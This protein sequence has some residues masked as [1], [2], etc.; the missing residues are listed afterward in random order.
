MRGYGT[1]KTKDGEYEGD[2][3]NNMQ[4]GEG[5]HKDGKT[6]KVTRGYW[7]RGELQK[8]KPVKI[9]NGFGMR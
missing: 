3:K 9:R 1:L 5:I 2:F 8:T 4:H 7:S 6:G